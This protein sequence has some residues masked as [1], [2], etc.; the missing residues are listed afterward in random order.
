MTER[1]IDKVLDVWLEGGPVVAPARLAEAAQLESRG[2][3]QMTVQARWRG[4]RLGTLIAARPLE[5]AV[6]SV[7]LA[8]A[9]VLTIDVGREAGGGASDT[10]PPSATE[11]PSSAS[12]GATPSPQPIESPPPPD[13]LPDR[14]YT[15]GIQSVTLS[16]ID[17]SF[18]IAGSGWESHGRPYISKSV[19]GPQ[20]AEAII[21]WAS[22]PDGASADPCTSVLTQTSPS[23]ADLAD[24]VADAEGTD[25]ISG[26]TEVV[27]GNRPAELVVVTVARDAGCD[28][29]YFYSWTP[30]LEGALWPETVSGDTI[31]AWIV[32][33]DGTIVFIAGATHADAGSGVVREIEDTV[34]S[35]E[36]ARRD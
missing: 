17:L 11:S 13:A 9:V 15:A 18:T 28:P 3:R 19:F 10:E 14:G 27:I 21:Y 31:R 7:V 33:V 2:S 24:A 6:L 34:D 4:S 8:A 5:F 30:F 35:M 20:G 1:D 23:A 16:D 36:F 12:L 22:Y 25:L 26:P 32:D 29:G